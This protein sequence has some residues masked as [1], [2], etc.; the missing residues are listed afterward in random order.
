MSKKG[1]ILAALQPGGRLAKYDRRRF[2]VINDLWLGYGTSDYYGANV[3]D[4]Q[5]T[6]KHI[7]EISA[8]APVISFAHGVDEPEVGLCL[9]ADGKCVTRFHYFSVETIKLVLRISDSEAAKLQAEC[10]ANF[11]SGELRRFGVAEDK[12]EELGAALRELAELGD[13]GEWL[14]ASDVIKDILEFDFGKID[15]DRTEGYETIDGDGD[16]DWD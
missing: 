1:D 11:D 10:I 3:K 4:P 14:S 9:F 13:E 16:D 7:E 12:I 8:V 5:K 6:P 2:V 15:E